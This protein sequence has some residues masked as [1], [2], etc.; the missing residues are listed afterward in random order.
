[1]TELQVCME[2]MLDI[3]TKWIALFLVNVIC[4]EMC[5]MGWTSS[6]V[7][8]MTLPTG[9]TSRNY[10]EARQ[11]V[12][13]VLLYNPPTVSPAKIQVSSRVG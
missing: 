13:E 2:F 7:G 12:W 6:A 9:A 8:H 5:H 3:C 10:S 4:G 11:T 1:M